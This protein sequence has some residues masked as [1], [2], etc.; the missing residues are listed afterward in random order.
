M[1]KKNAAKLEPPMKLG[2]G[3]WLKE[4]KHI[5][6][7]VIH[8]VDIF[9][10]PLYLLSG[11]VLAAWDLFAPPMLEEV[12]KRSFTFSRTNARIE[13]GVMGDEAGLYG[14]AYLPLQHGSTTVEAVAT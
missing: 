10:F 3:E 8:L 6:N 7:E 5:E 2:E 13:K 11:G 4:L 1:S 14:A 9:N 12:Q